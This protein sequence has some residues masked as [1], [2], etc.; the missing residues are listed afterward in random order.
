MDTDGLTELL[1]HLGRDVAVAEL[2]RNPLAD[3]GSTDPQAIL[4]LRKTL[5]QELP[6]VDG[7][8]LRC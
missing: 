2:A 3:P 4:N 5:L 7:M 1:Q 8:H 6:E